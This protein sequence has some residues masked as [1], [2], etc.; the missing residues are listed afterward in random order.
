LS[1]ASSGERAYVERGA[2]DRQLGVD[3]LADARLIVPFVDAE[4]HPDEL[5]DRKVGR[6]LAVRDRAALEQHPA[7][8]LSG[9]R[10]LPEQA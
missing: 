7:V 4:V 5:D 1:N 8:Q 6:R 10:E 9:V 2:E 3:A